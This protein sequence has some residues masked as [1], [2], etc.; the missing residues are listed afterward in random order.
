DIAA[1]EPIRPTNPIDRPIR[2]RLR[3]AHG[4]AQRADVEHAAA[5]CE[6][7]AAVRL[8]AGV[9]DFD[10]L[11]LGRGLDALDHRTPRGGAG[12]ALARTVGSTI[13]SMARRAISGVITG[14]GEYAP[15]PPVLG[16]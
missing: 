11:D 16:P 5:I 7:A 3:L 12:M 13:S 15:M 6:D 8:G 10:A 1:A 2:P 14:A 9:E 4:L